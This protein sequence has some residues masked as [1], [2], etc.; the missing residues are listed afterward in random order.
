MMTTAQLKEKVRQLINEAA[1]DS[2]V[3]LLSDDTRNID[4][5]IEALLPDA[6]LFVQTSS[7]SLG[8][9]PKKLS[10]T[11]DDIKIND[12][13]GTLL[14]PDDFVR[15]IS[16][17]IEGAG[18][19]CTVLYQ[20]NSPMAMVQ[21]NIYTRAGCC[22]PV[23]V[24]TVGDEGE[25]VLRFYSSPPGETLKVKHFVYEAK[26]VSGGTLSGNDE[27]LLKAVAYRCAALL[28]NVFEKTDSANMFFA[29]SSALCSSKQS[30][31]NE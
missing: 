20:A 3:T 25:R 15:L 23:C 2:D 9:N 30:V 26:Y 28:Y 29:I 22:K 16:F 12:N 13:C 14:L 18:R 4:E 5:H 27:A 10:L 1:N 7:N 24:E 19:P 6:V 21:G 8:V 11:N 17:D 31:N